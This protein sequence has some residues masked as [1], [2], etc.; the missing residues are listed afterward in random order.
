M[1]RPWEAMDAGQRGVFCTLSWMRA[2]PGRV[3]EQRR[4]KTKLGSGLMSVAV[5]VSCTGDK[6]VIRETRLGPPGGMGGFSLSRYPLR[7]DGPDHWGPGSSRVHSS[8][9]RGRPLASGDRG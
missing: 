9:R 5:G 7:W 4:S 2:T 6:R 3:S 8:G 1:T